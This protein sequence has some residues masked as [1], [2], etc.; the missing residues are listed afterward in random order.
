MRAAGHRF[1]PS[2]VS[3]LMNDELLDLLLTRL[4]AARDKRAIQALLRAITKERGLRRGDLR[5]TGTK[6]E[7]LHHIREG[8]DRGLL[9][10]TRLATLVDEL[11]ENGG[12]H[13]FLFD[14]TPDGL[15][16]LRPATLQ[17]AFPPMPPNPAP[18]MYADAPDHPQIYFVQKPDA[19]VVKQIHTATFWEKDEERS[20]SD[21]TERATIVVRRQRRAVNL[22]RIL[23]D[24]ERAEIRIDR[25]T[26]SLGD[27]DIGE[28][29]R[30]FLTALDPILNIDTH[31][32]ST[33]IWDGFR[34]IV[35]HRP[36]TYMSTDGAEDPSVKVSISNRRAGNTGQDVRDHS[37][38]DYAS[39][40]YVR[41][42][43]NIY[44]HTDRLVATPDP[45]QGDPERVHTILSPV[46]FRQPHVREDLRRR[47][48]IPG[49]PI[50][51]HR[52]RSKFCGLTTQGSTQSYLPC[53]ASLPQPCPQTATP[54]SMIVYSSSS[55]LRMAR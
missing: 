5:I 34:A 48:H 26:H 21:A 13:L 1:R 28:H 40:H 50:R 25:I 10:V 45:Q 36:G 44:W 41:H 38:Y 27:K 29:L 43:V 19:L 3:A 18:A 9:P 7:L 14:L 53:G 32:R 23:P 12:Q 6:E 31:L 51:C 30:A 39:A 47:D 11:E 46:C 37:S 20:Y 16:A 15:A 33:P 4:R 42:R 17:Q 2:P 52:A 49:G 35:N 22:F 54:S 8:I 55:C 24:Q